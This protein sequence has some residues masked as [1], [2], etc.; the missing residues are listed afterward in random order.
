[1]TPQTPLLIG[2]VSKSFTAT[3]V[4]QL[5]EAG[6]LDLDAPVQRYLPW[7]S[8]LPPPERRLCGFGPAA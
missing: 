6:Q 8:V 1:M 7:F 4:M 3:A 5:V 2:S